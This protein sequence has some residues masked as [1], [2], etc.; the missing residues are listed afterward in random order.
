MKRFLKYTLFSAILIV[1]W[2]GVIFL[3]TDRGWWHTSITQQKEPT[4]FI[5]SVQNELKKEFVGNMAMAIYKNG[6]LV[7]ESFHSKNTLVDQNTVFQVAS[8][9]KFVS[10][11][12]VMRLVQE[13]KLE[14]DIPV[15]NYLNR[16]QL[17]PSSFD[18][19]EVTVRR[20]LSHTAGLTDGL[21]YAGFE[22]IKEVQSLESSLTKAKDA[23]PGKSGITQVGIL[24][25]SEWRYSGG[26]F[27][28]LQLIVEEVSGQ[29]F[30]DY[31]VTQ[32]FEPLGMKSSFYQWNE[33]F[34][35][36]LCD[37]YNADGTKAPHYYYTS[38]AA[39]SL[40]TTLNDLEK[41]FI[42]FDGEQNTSKPL[43]SEYQNMMRQV[44]A[45]KLGAPFYGLGSFLFAELDNGQFVIGHDGQSS[46]PINT[47]FRYNSKTKDG[48]IMLTTGNTNFATRIAS[49]WVYINTGKI[50]ALL[51]AMQLNKITQIL[52]IGSILIV[53]IIL[54]IALS[55]KRNKRNV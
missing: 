17:P 14:L 15:A 39:T 47:A 55:R 51:F 20:L 32:I 6:M 36:R 50:D 27:T 45:S 21:G 49:D 33:K 24:P 31:M 38:Q 4:K 2:S 29:S 35:T 18:N 1:V 13:G 54:F 41:I 3:G 28:L 7:A 22:D 42:L 5:A 37:F 40:Y 9:S 19:N 43:L 53:I 52:I 23:D 34:R 8:L 25:G 44:E 48:I 16:W 11:I 12:G 30:N 26:G 46:P 10:A